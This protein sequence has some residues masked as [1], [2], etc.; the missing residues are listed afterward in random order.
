MLYVFTLCF[1][2]SPLGELSNEFMTQEQLKLAVIFKWCQACEWRM[3]DYHQL[4]GMMYYYNYNEKLMM[5][6]SSVEVRERAAKSFE[7]A[8]NNLIDFMAARCFP[9]NVKRAVWYVCKSQ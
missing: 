5:N 9:D 2:S 3:R 1:I 8:K 7:S 4:F 6:S